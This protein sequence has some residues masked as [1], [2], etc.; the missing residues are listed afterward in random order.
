MQ[1]TYDA[2]VNGQDPKAVAGADC[3][4]GTFEAGYTIGGVHVGRYL[5]TDREYKG[6]HYHII[7]WTN[8]PLQMIAYLGAAGSTWQQVIDFSDASGP[9]N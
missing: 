2:A 7:E 8:E 3:A 6:Y 9:V 4:S 1:E 5:C